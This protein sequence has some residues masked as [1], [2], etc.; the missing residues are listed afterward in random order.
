MVARKRAKRLAVRIGRGMNCELS[1]HIT[2]RE[3]QNS[4][5]TD[6]RFTNTKRICA[7]G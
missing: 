1:L 6:I 2:R 5:P 7:V 4:N 3:R